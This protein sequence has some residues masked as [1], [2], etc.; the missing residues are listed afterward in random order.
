MIARVNDALKKKHNRLILLMGPGGKGCQYEI[1]EC[2]VTPE[3]VGL[4]FQAIA[5][6][7]YRRSGVTLLGVCHGRHARPDSPRP[8]LERDPVLRSHTTT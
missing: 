4:R 5:E 1:Y 6:S 8:P 2:R 7:L 3:M